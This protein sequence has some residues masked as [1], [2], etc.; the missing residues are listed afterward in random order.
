MKSRVITSVVYVAIWLGLIVMKWLVP[1][2]YGALGLDAL[3]CAV[4]IIA[5]LE[6][7]KAVGVM[8]GVQRALSVAFCAMCVPLYVLVQMTTQSGFLAVSCAFGIYVLLLSGVSVFNHGES[9]VKGMG[10]AV[11]A[12][13]YC[14]VLSVM[15]SSINHISKPDSATNTLAAIILL[16]FVVTF[17]D[18]GAFIIGS[19][20]GRYAPMKLAPK[21]SPNKTVIGAAGGVVGGALGAVIAYYIYYGFTIAWG[22]AFYYSGS[23]PL[24]VVFLFVGIVASL[25]AQ[26]GDLFESAIKREC[27]IKDTG[28]ILPGHGGVLDRFDGMLFASVVVLLSFGIIV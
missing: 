21:V 7:T 1:A 24:V 16:F 13:V 17:T 12:M 22:G 6:F 4:S 19:T 8:S 15:L 3:F 11:F 2:G 27:D 28:K 25:F 23:L 5:S 10:N 26:M 18:S 20:L 14:G 9:T